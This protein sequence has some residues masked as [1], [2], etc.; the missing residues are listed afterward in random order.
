M[1]TFEFFLVVV[2]CSVVVGYQRFRGPCCLHLLGC[3]VM[4]CC[5]RIPTFQR[6][7]LPPSSVFVTSCSVVVEYQLFGSLCDILPSY[8]TPSQPTRPRLQ[9][10]PPLEPQIWSQRISHCCLNHKYM[11]KLNGILHS[12]KHQTCLCT[13]I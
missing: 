4:W 11:I 9:S 2:P 7:M 10:S 5:G 12:S 13:L 1:C 3:D 6:S 8:Y